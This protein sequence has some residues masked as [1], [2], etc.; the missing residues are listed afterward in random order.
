MITAVRGQEI[1]PLIWKAVACRPHCPAGPGASGRASAQGR[2]AAEEA[3]ER[4]Q[5]GAEQARP[6]RARAE[7]L[8]AVREFEAQL[9]RLAGEADG[10]AADAMEAR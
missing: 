4:Q 1:T 5:A 10:T 7:L 8:E 2:Q 9:R 3:A 6:E